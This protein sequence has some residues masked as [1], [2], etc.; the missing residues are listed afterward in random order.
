[1]MPLFIHHLHA[2]ISM[3]YSA[4]THYA[5]C[6]CCSGLTRACLAFNIIII[7]FHTLSLCIALAL[8][9]WYVFG[10]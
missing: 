8:A 6:C 5:G 1:M 3:I 2:F 9:T 4:L 10:E 7:I